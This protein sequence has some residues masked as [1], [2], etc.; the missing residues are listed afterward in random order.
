M[1]DQRNHL[2]N[3]T[4]RLAWLASFLVAVALIVPAALVLAKPNTQPAVGGVTLYVDSNA[5]DGGSGNNWDEAYNQLQD[6]LN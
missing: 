6:A 2:I 5:P 3:P 1:S 4:A